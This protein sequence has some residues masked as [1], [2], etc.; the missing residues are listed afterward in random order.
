MHIPEEWAQTSASSPILPHLPKNIQARFQTFVSLLVSTAYVLKGSGYAVI[1][2]K[3]LCFGFFLSY[4]WICFDQ[5][6]RLC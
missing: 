2:L 1:H 6:A 4:S 3:I 5:S